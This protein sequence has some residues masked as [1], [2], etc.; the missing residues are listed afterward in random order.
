MGWELGLTSGP[1]DVMQEID[2]Y[3]TLST[4]PQVLQCAS[5]VSCFGGF[6]SAPQWMGYTGG[7]SSYLADRDFCY[8]FTG[9]LRL[10]DWSGK[11]FD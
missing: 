5:D 11:F 7:S 8:R 10:S 6:F 9:V 3:G 4:W 1:K 2:D